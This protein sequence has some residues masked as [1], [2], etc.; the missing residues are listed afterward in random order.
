[1]RI[2]MTVAALLLSLSSVA[3]AQSWSC[4]GPQ[5]GHPTTA[6]RQAFVE[7]VS[8]AA[9]KAE[10]DYGVPAAAIA[11]MAIIESGYGFTRTAVNAHNYFG[12]KHF[13]K[14]AAEGR[15]YFILECQPP[16]DV[17]N[18]YIIFRDLEESVDFVSRK[19]ANLEH[20]RA[21]TLSYKQARLNGADVK[22]ATLK[23]IEG[24]S[25]PYNWRPAEYVESVIK[26]MNNPI[27]P[28]A[29]INAELTLLR[30]SEKSD[31]QQPAVEQPKP[32]VGFEYALTKIKPWSGECDEPTLNFPNWEG[33][34]VRRCKWSDFGVTVR[35]YMLN[36]SK[37]KLA[38]WI[39]SACIAARVEKTEQCIDEL[40]DEI[41][42]AS[43]MGVFP[44]S[45]FIPESYGGNKCYLFRDGVTIY[46]KG[47]AKL[48]TNGCPE[49][50]FSSEPAT[51]AMRFA[52]IA[53]TT[54]DDYRAA[55]GTE[56]VGST[57]DI[58]WLKVVRQLYQNA[59]K[60]DQNQLISAR[61]IA[62]KAAGKLK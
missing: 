49:T 32:H 21:D 59:W 43:S 10:Q 45:G 15:S 18:R 34:P 8:T 26:V 42:T 16:E 28:S 41:K 35:T 4:Y 51:K 24:I 52:R 39:D 54:R 56:Q 9:I 6:E 31:P 37:E 30:L 2:V 20:Y 50:D 44:V 47:Y 33:F 23:W 5:S 11:A 3:S 58:R 13:S 22:T 25:D 7:R 29:S 46:T 17:G 19:L 60:S 48:A 57:G 53:L 14:Q 12:W 62:L 55:G 61:A 40:I 27:S 1:M 36:P 38:R